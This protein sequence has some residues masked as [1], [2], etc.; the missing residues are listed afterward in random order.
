MQNEQRR[1]NARIVELQLLCA[2][3][4]LTIASLNTIMSR[5]NLNRTVDIRTKCSQGLKNSRSGTETRCLQIPLSIQLRASYNYSTSWY[6]DADK[7]AKILSCGSMPAAYG[8]VRMLQIPVCDGSCVLTIHDGILLPNTKCLIMDC[9]QPLW[10]C[11]CVCVS[12]YSCMHARVCACMR[13]CS[14]SA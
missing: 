5:V 14:V 4:L 3:S 6:N 9:P 11:L 1:G 2:E 12:I 13:V 7:H 10:A 8:T